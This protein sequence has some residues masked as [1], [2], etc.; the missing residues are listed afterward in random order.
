M[1]NEQMK[2]HP[3]FQVGFDTRTFI[4]ISEAEAVYL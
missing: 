4:G 3:G 2:K 1:C